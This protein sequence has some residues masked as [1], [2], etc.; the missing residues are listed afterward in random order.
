MRLITPAL[1]KKEKTVFQ[2]CLQSSNLYTPLNADYVR[3][4]FYHLFY[5]AMHGKSIYVNFSPADISFCG[6]IFADES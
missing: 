4:F 2:K 1:M 6:V 5:R 3:A